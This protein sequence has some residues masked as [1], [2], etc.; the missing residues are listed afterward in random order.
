MRLIILLCIWG[1]LAIYLPVATGIADVDLMIKTQIELDYTPSDMKLSRDGKW[2]YMLTQ[3][4]RLLVY[5]YEGNLAGAFDVGTGFSHI[6]PGPTDTEIYLL[7]KNDK[8]LQI[9]ELNYPRKIDSSQSPFKGA[10]DAPVVI[11]EYTDFQCPYCAQLGKIFN[12]L[13]KLYPG[14]LKI[15]YKSY[16]LNT[17]KYSWKAAAAAMAA[18]E[19]GQFWSFHDRLF[20][21]FDNL[22]DDKIM[23]IR[24][25]F[26]FDTPEFE[27]LMKSSKIRNKVA[28]DKKE[29]KSIG[30]HS[31]PTVFIN[32]KLIKDKR[33]KN[34]TQVID[35]VLQSSQK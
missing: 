10:A 13:L 11:V 16:P 30:V 31:T 15:V 21:H 1:A 18:H 34:F 27:T 23:Q 24:K 22:D 25:E 19:M 14:K 3:E 35:R 17:H 28:D 26:G 20:E 9:A 12:E 29:G 8:K 5:S 6:E 7:D 32:G 2:L 33:L 4:G